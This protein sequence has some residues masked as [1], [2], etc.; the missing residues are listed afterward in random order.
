MQ[1]LL[2]GIVKFRKD[3]F[4]THKEL[5]SSLKRQ[6]KPHTLFISCSDSRINPNLITKTLP[7]ELFIIRNI[8]NLV[9][10]YRYTAEYV[11]TT[12][13]IEYAVL[14]LNVENIIICG[15]SNCGGCDAGLNLPGL[16]V[17]MPHTKKWLELAR[18]AREKVLAT[19]NSEDPEAKEWMM[20]QF[21]V[22]EQLKNLWSYPY[23]R[24]RVNAGTL[25]LSG[26]YYII[27]TGE[28]FIY[29]REEGAFGLAN[30]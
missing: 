23:I 21:N 11:S 4:D 1:K 6:Q 28:V 19:M 10:P 7:G 30:G 8:A 29:D 17:S 13:A 18:P 20:E 25:Q 15:H 16:L 5:F 2:D 9:P 26:W 14:A 24:E 27:E 3:D 22:I 12:S